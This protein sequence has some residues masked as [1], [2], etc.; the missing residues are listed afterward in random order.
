ML[1]NIII[2]IVLI[3]IISG[4]MG[5]YFFSSIRNKNF[6][7]N[8]TSGVEKQINNLNN[9]LAQLQGQQDSLNLI[10]G[11]AGPQGNPGPAGG[12]YVKT[13][14]LRNLQYTDLVSDRAYGSGENAVVYLSDENYKSHQNWTLSANNTLSNQYGGCLFG[15]TTTG[16]VYMMPCSKEPDQQWQ[17]D[18]NGRL[19]LKTK[20]NKCLTAVLQGK[21][22]EMNPIEANKPGKS[23]S[24]TNIIRLKVGECDNKSFPLSQQWA[25]R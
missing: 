14:P 9:Q 24:A 21:G 3:V 20:P 12:T 4:A 6:I 15:N 1:I 16:D 23:K 2:L 18:K 7:E 13:G 17:Y 5:I 8:K 10:Q 11:P 25:F 19:F 22:P